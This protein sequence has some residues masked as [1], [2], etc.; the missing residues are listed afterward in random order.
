MTTLLL[1]RLVRQRSERGSLQERCQERRVETSRRRG[2][3]KD[4]LEAEPSVSSVDVKQTGPLA[5]TPLVRQ[6]YE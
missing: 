4:D 6:L 1:M 3:A 5:A 2:V